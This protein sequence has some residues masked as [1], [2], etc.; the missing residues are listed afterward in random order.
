MRS[1]PHPA[2]TPIGHAALCS[3]ALA[4]CAAVPNSAQAQAGRMSV[5]G[6]VSHRCWVAP[7][8]ALPLGELPSIQLAA[9][10]SVRCSDR[11][12]QVQVKQNEP[13]PQLSL[14][15]AAGAELATSNPTTVVIS[16]RI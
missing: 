9:S 2:K 7:T 12:L 1:H 13:L 11:G 16:P 10:A 4:I 3:L 8:A 5:S 15:A 14:A 6:Y